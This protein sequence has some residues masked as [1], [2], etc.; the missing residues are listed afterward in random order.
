MNNIVNMFNSN[1][2]DTFGGFGA[3]DFDIATTPALFSSDYSYHETDKWVTYRTDT[4][5]ALG[6]HSSRHKAVAPKDVIKTAREI[7]GAVAV[8][9]NNGQ[10]VANNTIHIASLYPIGKSI[11]KILKKAHAIADSTGRIHEHAA[12][13]NSC[14]NCIWTP[15]G[16]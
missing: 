1:A 10:R 16:N 11:A 15:R 8:V 7:N 6:I 9:W 13:C 3:A 2:S 14:P 5:Q 4:K 12:T